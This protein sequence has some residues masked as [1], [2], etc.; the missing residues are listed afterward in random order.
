MGTT[1][2]LVEEQKCHRGTKMTDSPMIIKNP[3]WSIYSMYL[4]EAIHL[5][6][7]IST[8]WATITHTAEQQVNI[9]NESNGFQQILTTSR[10]ASSWAWTLLCPP[11]IMPPTLNQSLKE[12]FRTQKM[13]S[14]LALVYQFAWKYTEDISYKSSRPNIKK[15]QLF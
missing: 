13:S 4:E 14:S 7:F 6:T 11:A 1:R 2:M 15:G 12:K 8:S 10:P 9:F 3:M 5:T